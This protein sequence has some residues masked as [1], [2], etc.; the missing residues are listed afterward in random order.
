MRNLLLTLILT[1]FT[2]SCA[3]NN[4]NDVE[5]IVFY[6]KTGS[7]I[8]LYKLY[9]ILDNQLKEQNINGKVVKS[10][11]K[12]YKSDK[13]SK[14]VLIGFSNENNLNIGAELTEF[15]KGFKLNNYFTI[16]NE[17]Q[18]KNNE[19]NIDYKN[20]NLICKSN[21]NSN[22]IKHSIAIVEN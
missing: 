17:C 12:E 8:E 14:I 20:E 3:S 4:Y 22:C 11:I 19:T 18:T 10:Q 21:K 6:D 2:F 1:I 9:D 5:N 13:S 15:R 7:K 16:C